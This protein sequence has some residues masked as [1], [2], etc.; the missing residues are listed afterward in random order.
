M[1]TVSGVHCKPLKRIL[2]RRLPRQKRQQE[3]GREDRVNR[4]RHSGDCGKLGLPLLNL[5]ALFW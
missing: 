1:E 4:Q 3:H 2:S 5:L